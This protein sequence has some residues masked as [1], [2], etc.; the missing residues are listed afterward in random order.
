MAARNSFDMT[1]AWDEATALLRANRQVVLVVAGVFFFLPYLAL[2]LLL[3]DLGAA[4]GGQAPAADPDAM[5]EAMLA[6]VAK[7]WWAL[8]LIAVLQAIGSLAL[9][10]MLGKSGRPTLGSAL[11]EGFAGLI[12][13]FAANV[14]VVLALLLVLTL[15]FSIFSLAGSP[16]LMAIPVGL[17]LPLL[18]YVAVKVSLVSPA[19]AIENSR[20]PVAAIRRSWM[21]TKGNSFRIFAFYALLVISFIVI[22]LMVTL[23]A[24]LVGALFGE[25]V[26]LWLTAIVGSLVNAAM[27]LVFL[28]VV[29]AVH[30]QLSGH[31]T[32]AS[33]PK[34]G[35]GVSGE[36]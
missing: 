2:T 33:V 6:S 14:L 15:L 17:S 1:S 34:A 29:A 32:R 5:A 4:M 12:P 35:K 31:A 25:I 21:L 36:S 10:A 9:L 20:N 8:L 16:A 28:A 11:G 22:S 26:N 27:V 23:V 18:I 7:N 30:R 13:Y 24:G 3:P 19:I